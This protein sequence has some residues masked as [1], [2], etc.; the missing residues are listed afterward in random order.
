VRRNDAISILDDLPRN[1]RRLSGRGEPLM[2]AFEELSTDFL[3]FVFW[4]ALAMVGFSAVIVA[5]GETVGHFTP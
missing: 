3:V 1:R 5:V 2:T 4:L